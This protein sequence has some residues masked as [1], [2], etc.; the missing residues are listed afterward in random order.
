MDTDETRPHAPDPRRFRD[1]S[2]KLLILAATFALWSSPAAFAG[3]DEEFFEKKVRPILVDRCYRC[4]NAAKKQGGG[5]S[6]DTKGGWAKGGDSGPA[7]RPGDPDG[8]PVVQAVRWQDEALRMP[9]KE[10]GG[11]LSADQIA[12]LETWIRRGAFDPR[13][14]RAR[15]GTHLLGGDVPRA[16]GLVEP[17]ARRHADRPAG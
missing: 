1:L 4:H 9:P 13:A 2:V 15:R 14:R 8:S 12:D 3:D 16:S 17:P 6:L 10:A 11:K 5:L 7:I